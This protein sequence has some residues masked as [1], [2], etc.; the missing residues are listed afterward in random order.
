M[1]RNFEVFH[2]SLIGRQGDL[3]SPPYTREEWLR[4]AFNRNFQFMHRRRVFHWV[5][6]YVGDGEIIGIVERQTTRSRHLP[7]SEGAS[8]FTESIWQGA[9]VIIDPA[10]HEL[11]QRVSFEVDPDVGRFRHKE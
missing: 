3:F 6:K 11:G 1:A 10:H 5:P 9:I 8:E 4:V 7:P 2:L